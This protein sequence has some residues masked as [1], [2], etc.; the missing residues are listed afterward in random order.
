VRP[1]GPRAPHV[2]SGW[3]QTIKSKEGR[4]LRELKLTDHGRRIDWELF[5]IERQLR[6]S[7]PLSVISSGKS[8]LF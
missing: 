3:S 6:K 1:A 2:K 5:M 4:S 7:A 8:Y